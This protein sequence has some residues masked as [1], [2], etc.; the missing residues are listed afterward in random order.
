MPS[1]GEQ[2]ERS[3]S[4]ATRFSPAPPSPPG[5]GDVPSRSL[6]SRTPRCYLLLRWS[7]GTRPDPSAACRLAAVQVLI[8]TSP[9]GQG[10]VTNVPQIV[11]DWLGTW[12]STRSRV[13]HGRYVRGSRWGWDTHMSL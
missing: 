7:R 10:D 3:L 4:A 2:A 5:H 6:F 12:G 8:G 9:H 13:L 1:G 11:A